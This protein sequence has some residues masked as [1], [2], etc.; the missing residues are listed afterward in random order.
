MH[1]KLLTATLVAAVATHATAAGAVFTMSDDAAANA[2]LAFTRSDDG[3]LHP[4]GAFPTG[5]QGSGGGEDVLG[6]QGAA[7]LTEDGRFLVVVDAG[8]DEISAL[9]VRGTQLTLTSRAP[10]GGAL[11]VSVAEHHGLVYVLDAGGAGNI[12]GLRLDDDGGLTPIP[13]SVRPLSASGA[14]GAQI[15]FDASG[16]T[17]AVTEKA[18]QAISLYRV[19][20]DG[21]AS[22][23][24]AFPSAGSTP[25]GFAF[26]R[27]DVLAVS[28]AGDG[29]ASSYDLE[30]GTLELVSARVPDGQQ[31]ACW[32]VTTGNGR[33]A[34]VAKAGSGGVQLP[35]RSARRAHAARRDG[36]RDPGRQAAR[37]GA[38]R[39]R[40]VPVRAR[41]EPRC[42]PVLRGRGGR[43]LDVAGRAGLRP[44]PPRR[45]ARG[46][47]A[48][49][50]VPAG[51]GA[52]PR[53]ALARRRDALAVASRSATATP[54]AQTAR[55][56]PP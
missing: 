48:R 51:R 17:L 45:R 15:G 39:G 2:V 52:P 42:D 8:S 25:F 22:G 50:A 10:S 49:P 20:G 4:A 26:T 47:V 1:A 5:G 53:A 9:R 34:F 33:Q 3:S 23:P 41:S 36:R 13:G 21:R 56:R 6:S 30:D 55:T 28:E 27:R 37:H 16:E 40:P 11:P 32:L 54:L 14:A 24:N 44:A 29:S 35:H 31:A 43:Q 18:T 38:L 19:G 12:A 46:A 7:T